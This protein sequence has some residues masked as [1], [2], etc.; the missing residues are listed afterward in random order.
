DL[1]ELQRQSAAYAAAMQ[2]AGL[3]VQFLP[4]AAHDHFSILDELSA[5]DGQLCRVLW[6]LAGPGTGKRAR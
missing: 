2:V 4:L 6:E 3:P 5:P 1:P